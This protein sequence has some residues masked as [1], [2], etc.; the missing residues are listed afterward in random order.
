[1]LGERTRTRWVV[2][3]L[4]AVQTGSVVV[5]A[6]VAAAV[7][8]AV[9]VV[10][11]AAAAAEATIPPVAVAVAAA[12]ETPVAGVYTPPMYSVIGRTRVS[13]D[14]IGAPELPPVQLVADKG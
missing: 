11:A 13:W 3:R 7:G 5:V 10:A 6:A 14:A 8:E 1:M 9:V 2:L 4:A 12:G